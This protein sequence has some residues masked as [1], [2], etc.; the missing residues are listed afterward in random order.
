L[1]GKK[2]L[3][4]PFMQREIREKEEREREKEF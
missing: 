1:S 4:R 2:N 3:F